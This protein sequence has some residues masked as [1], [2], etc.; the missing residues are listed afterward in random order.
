MRKWIIALVLLAVVVTGGYF[1]YRAWQQRQASST[2]QYQTAVINNG[3]LTA[4]IGATGTVRSFQ[5]A[6]LSWKTSGTAASVKVSVGQSVQ[7]GDLLAELETGSLPQNVILAQADLVN[8]QKALDDLR[9][10][11]ATSVLALQTVQNAQAVVIEAERALDKVETDDYQNKIDQAHEDMINAKDELKTAQEDFDPYKDFDPE[12]QTRKNA[13]QKL[14][15]A[16]LKYDET[17]RV[18]DMLNLDKDKASTALDLAKARLADVQREY[19]RIQDGPNAGDI[20]VLEA[21]IRAAQATLDQARL[22]APFAG[23]I[24]VVDILPGDQVTPGTT[25]FRMD[26]LSELEVEV[27]LSEVDVN[28]IFVGQPVK[29]TFDA[30][31]GKE[32]QGTVIEVASIG[33]PVQGV[34]EFVVLVQITNADESVRP[35]MTAAVNIIVDQLDSVLLVPNRAVRLQNGQRVV[36]ILS[37]GELRTV[38]VTLGSSSDTYSEVTAGGLRIGDVVVLNPP[39]VFETNGPPPFVN[40]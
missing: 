25:S 14:D 37:N 36:Y 30:I 22:T 7:A 28:R 5:S 32:Y 23:T 39:Q 9:N 33:A 27:Q 10:Q 17:V 29:L 1:I 35:G 24:T 21:R 12:N 11:Q 13:Q 19:A 18:L 16:Q 38:E 8:A 34:V 20:A 3:S 2:S 4:S 40:R 6:M 26:D 15:D 31:L